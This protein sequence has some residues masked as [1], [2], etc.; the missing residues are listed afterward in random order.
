MKTP[1]KISTSNQELKFVQDALFSFIN[2]VSSN[3]L[4]DIVL[5][6]NISLSSSS[7]TNVSHGLGRNYRFWIV[8]KKNANANIYESTS[9]HPDIYIKL[10][11]TANTT[12]SLI[13][14]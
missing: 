2:N 13:V 4:M 7:V 6:E 9:D 5:L 3:P 10:N 12:V 1:R 8:A 14:G 11:T